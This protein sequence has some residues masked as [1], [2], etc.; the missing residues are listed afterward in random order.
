[1][2]CVIVTGVFPPDIGGPAT[3][4]P[5]IAAGLT[6]RGHRVTVVTLSD[7]VD[8][9][10]PARPYAV[11]RLPRR[12]WKPRRQVRTIVAIARAA[13]EASVLLASGLALE[14]AAASRLTR[15]PLVL[16]VVSDFAW[17][18]ATAWGWTTAGLADFLTA[19]QPGRVRALQGLRTWWTRQASCVV[20]PSRHLAGV[21]A[22]WSIPAG[23]ISV[24]PNGVDV[25]T[26]VTPVAPPLQTPAT[27]VTASRLVAVKRLDAVLQALLNVPDVG[28]VIIG[29]GPAGPHLRELAG[30][31]GLNER[32]YF[33]GGQPLDRTLALMA[34]C[35]FFVM[36]SAHE[37]LPNALLEAM[38]LGLP[39][40]VR[41]AGGMPEVV[42]H[43]V[44]GLV[45]RTEE[46]FVQALRQLAQDGALRRR[47]GE[48]AR[49]RAVAEF[50]LASMVAQTEVVL[51]AAAA[52]GPAQSG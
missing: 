52:A 27:A 10:E 14:A 36:H 6:R 45:V 1:M 33:A 17:E 38:A 42:G 49:A 24:I 9:E 7:H 41:D 20:V 18:R 8:E 16:K 19:R 30:R 29:D 43:R 25:E 12:D 23:R 31:L 47:L 11:V 2:R 51:A 28:L 39:P 44:H 4:V 34:G 3:Y 5:Q 21:V 13:R 37:G 35:D 40:I 46:E 26:P 48:A 22:G 15:R 50:S 32:V